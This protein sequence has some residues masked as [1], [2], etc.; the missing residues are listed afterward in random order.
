M[1]KINLKSDKRNLQL[2]CIIE[3]GF[4]C[5]EVIRLG[6]ILSRSLTSF[7]PENCIVDI[8][9]LFFLNVYVSHITLNFAGYPVTMSLFIFMET[10]EQNVKRH[11]KYGMVKL[12]VAGARH[13][14]ELNVKVQGKDELIF[15][16]NMKAFR[17]KLWLWETQTKN[18][19]VVPL[20]IQ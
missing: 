20:E 8:A 11:N 10:K 13:L 16:D 9:L 6:H 18:E 4:W 1:A 5:G 19:N 2:N 7:L 14:H 12:L 15:Y 3:Q 17:M